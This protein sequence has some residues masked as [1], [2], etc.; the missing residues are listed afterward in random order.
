MAKSRKLY[1]KKYRKEH[2]EYIEKAKITSKKYIEKNKEKVKIWISNWE[3][4]NRERRRQLMMKYRKGKG[5][6]T[7]KEYYIKNRNTIIKK[8]KIYC[9]N[10]RK[11]INN[12]TRERYLKDKKFAIRMRLGCLLWIALRR[13]TQTGKIMTSREYGINYKAIIEHLKPFPED[14]SKFEIDHIK[15]LCSFNL[16]DP[17]QIREAFAPENHQWLTIQENRRKSGKLNY[18]VL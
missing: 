4:K 14:L 3:K 15:P 16:E 18:K 5:K 13:Y 10:N 1:M 11:K 6:I 2:P 7:G 9:K 17:E 8:T 12:R